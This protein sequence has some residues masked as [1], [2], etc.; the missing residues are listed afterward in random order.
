[1]RNNVFP[2]LLIAAALSLAAEQPLPELIIEPVD[3]GSTLLIRNS[4]DQALTGFFIELVDYPGSSYTLWQEDIGGNP[5]PPHSERKIRIVN[6]TVGAVPEYVKLRAAAYA[7]GSTVG[8]PDRVALLIGRRKALLSAALELNRRLGSASSKDAAIMDLKQWA[9]T[10]RPPQTK[11]RGPLTQASVDRDV[12]RALIEATL[13]RLAANDVSAEQ[14][15][16]AQ[17]AR[18]L[19]TALSR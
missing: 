19:S 15:R 14:R 9:G 1:M 6:M 3:G 8:V 10:M 2:S 11:L 17:L 16:L 7:D 4:S 12:T 13:S 5:I 18:D